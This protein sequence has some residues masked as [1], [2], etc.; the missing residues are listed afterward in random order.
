MK[1]S[2]IIA[3]AAFSLFVL[4]SCSTSKPVELNTLAGKWNIVDVNGKPLAVTSADETPYVGF[5]VV[6]GSVSGFAGCNR[7]MASF[8]TDLPAGE[9]EMSQIAATRMACPDMSTEQ[10]VIQALSS[11]KGYKQGKD[12]RIELISSDGESVITLQKVDN[13]VS[14]DNLNGTW[15]ITDINGAEIKPAEEG[16]EAPSVMFDASAHTYSFVTGC[17]NIS[18]QYT[19]TYTDFTFDD[20][21]ATMRAC[22]DMTVEDAV[23]TVLPQIKSFGQVADGSYAFYNANNDILLIISKE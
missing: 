20:G 15:K 16:A 2:M 17:N 21:A 14:A 3:S 6:N 7:I 5:D 22:P 10:S 18:G 9:L 8:A 4:G 13:D 1:H 12:G 23:K 19:S 11:V